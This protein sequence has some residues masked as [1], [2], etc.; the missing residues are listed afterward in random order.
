MSPRLLF[1]LLTLLLLSGCSTAADR[2]PAFAAVPLEELSASDQARVGLL[3]EKACG[4]PP[5]CPAG[6]ILE[7]WGLDYIKLRSRVAAANLEAK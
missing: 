6:A 3:V 2:A 5:H 1:S 4:R 7:Q